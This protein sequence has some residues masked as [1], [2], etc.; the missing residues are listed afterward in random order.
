MGKKLTGWVPGRDSLDPAWSSRLRELEN[1]A[2]NG[3]L[4]EEA[5]RKYGKA[6]A[7]LDELEMESKDG[8]AV[9]DEWIKARLNLALVHLRSQLLH[10]CIDCCDAV[11][12][13]RPNETKA[14]YR[15]EQALRRLGRT[16]KAAQ[17]LKEAF[18]QR[19]GDIMLRKGFDNFTANLDEVNPILQDLPPDLLATV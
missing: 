10:E 9:L 4:L 8:A 12:Q 7:Y 3:S 18:W 15:S 5:S 16:R 1:R 2:L 13:L 17:R 14:L 11:L 6:L 19:P